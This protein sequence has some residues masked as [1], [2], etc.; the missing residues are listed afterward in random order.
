MLGIDLLIRDYEQQTTKYQVCLAWN[1]PQDH[2][3]RGREGS[4]LHSGLLVLQ[5]HS[6]R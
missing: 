4:I 2:D 3:V 5:V 1:K 6:L